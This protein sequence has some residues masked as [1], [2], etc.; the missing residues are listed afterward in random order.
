MSDDPRCSCAEL[1][2][3]HVGPEGACICCRCPGFTDDWSPVESLICEQWTLRLP[4]YRAYRWSRAWH[5]AGRLCAM[6]SVIRQGDTVYEVGAEEGDFGALYTSWGAKVVIVEPA[7]KCWPSIRASFEANGLRPYAWV[8]GFL[9][10]HVW[11]TDTNRD[12]QIGRSDWPEE[13]EGELIPEHGFFHLGEH[14]GVAAATTLDALAHR[15]AAPPDVISIDVEGGELHVLRGAVKVLTELHP[16]VFVSVHEAFLRDLYDID[17]ADVYTFM[18]DL[19]YER[20]HLA[21]D[22]EIH[23][24]FWH[25]EGRRL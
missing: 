12:V 9:A 14:A 19:G 24:C 13:A 6:H 17:A 7:E 25:P 20:T 16:I 23:E 5:E 2:S 11:K 21:T 15:I 4:P 8:R 10:D 18:A 1:L 3:Q 22:H